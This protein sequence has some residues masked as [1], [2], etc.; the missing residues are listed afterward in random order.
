MLQ[1][2]HPI[3]VASMSY[4]PTMGGDAV[5]L[6]KSILLGKPYEK[7]NIAPTYV[8]TKDNVAQFLDNAY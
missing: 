3:F 5:R 1:K 4:F 2:G 7:K 6:A 8:V